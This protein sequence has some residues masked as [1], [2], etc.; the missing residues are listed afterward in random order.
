MRL[1]IPSRLGRKH[2]QRCRRNLLCQYDLHCVSLDLLRGF[3][4]VKADALLLAEQI[5]HPHHGRMRLAFAA[6]V[7]GDGVGVHAEALRHFVL[8]EIELLA[9]DEQLFSES[10]F[11]H[12]DSS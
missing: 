6:L 2:G 5:E 3:I 7:L 1:D 9:G 8:I 11:W 10:Q 4:L 12:E